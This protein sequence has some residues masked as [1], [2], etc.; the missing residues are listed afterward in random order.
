MPSRERI[1]DALVEHKRVDA[2]AKSLGLGV[3]R[4]YRWM[5]RYDLTL[6]G[7]LWSY[8][9]A[10]GSEMAPAPAPKPAEPQQPG[11]PP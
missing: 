7:V 6:K 4:M 9:S 2:A 11:F 8:L 5:K 10:P 1:I 3:R